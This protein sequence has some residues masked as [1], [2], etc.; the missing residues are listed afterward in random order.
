MSDVDAWT[1]LKL[2]RWTTSFF[3]DKGIDNPRLDAEL[4]IAHVL[5]LD[6]V[7]VYL[8]YD[9]PLTPEELSLIRPLVK[10]RGQREPLQYILGNTEFWSLEFKVSPAVLIPRADTEVLVEEALK[11]ADDVGELLDIGTGSGAIALSFA[12]EKVRWQVTGFDI[13][14]AAL[15]V[16]RG[17][18]D[19]HTLESRCR[20]LLGDLA[21]LPERSFDLVV[22]NPPYISSSEYEALMPEVRNHEPSQALLA[23]ADGLDC[24]R[25]LAAQV[26]KILKPGGWLLCE[27]GCS[28]EQ[29][30]FD[31]LQK[32]GLNEIYCRQDY[33]G[34]PRVVG[35]RRRF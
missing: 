28:Q 13:S 26:D 10:R 29:P 35:G 31:L 9:R 17:N 7:G 20:F 33:A 22:S 19:N 21:Q 30:V 8:N 2:L 11:K 25:L 18:A 5:K 1:L 34:N 14:A 27:I 24:Y 32:A 16:A 15:A 3:Q 6:R 23:G 12:Y 4:L